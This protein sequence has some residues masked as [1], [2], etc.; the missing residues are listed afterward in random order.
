MPPSQPAGN[1]L[2]GCMQALCLTSEAACSLWAALPPSHTGGTFVA[3][4][5]AAKLRVSPALHSVEWLMPSVSSL[6]NV[7]KG[8][9]QYDYK[10]C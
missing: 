9:F 6:G 1:A 3:V 7:S 2:R 8:H 4:A 5:G 10:A